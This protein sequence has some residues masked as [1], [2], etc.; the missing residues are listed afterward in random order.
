MQLINE[1]I[2]Y[3]RTDEDL[4]QEML[5]HSRFDKCADVMNNLLKRILSDEIVHVRKFS[6]E[7][8]KN[9]RF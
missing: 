4:T 7:E 9:S 2:T 3:I 6:A 8:L 1:R 5:L